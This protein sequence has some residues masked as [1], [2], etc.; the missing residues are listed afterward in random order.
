[1]GVSVDP[2]PGAHLRSDGD[3]VPAGVYRVVGR[4]EASVT[5][6]EVGD[7]AGSRVHTGRVERVARGALPELEP[8]DPPATGFDIA[9]VVDAVYF[10]VRAIPSNLAGRPGQV[11]LGVAL[12]LAPVL[13]SGV[14]P[15]LSAGVAEAMELVGA[16]LLG[17]A[18][19][20][21]PK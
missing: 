18:A 3:P 8:T 15:G 20:G 16:L 13:G 10:S 7:E 2:E 17:A 5:L 1:M 14:V 9:G 12:V 6:L 4:N 11:L 21:V 19:A